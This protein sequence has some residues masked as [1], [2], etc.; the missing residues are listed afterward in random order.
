[1][2]LKKITLIVIIAIISS[3]SIRTFGTVFPQ[4]FNNIHMVKGTILVNTFFILSHL[5]FW[6]LF[7]RDYASLKGAVL[8]KTCLLP[9][10]GS[11]AVSLLYLKKLPFVFDMEIAFPLFL[12]NPYVDAFVPA[13]SSIF[14]LIFF[15]V[16][17]NSLESEE[18]RMLEKP[19]LS[20]IGGIS[21]FLVLHLIVLVNFIT[22]NT[23]EWLEHMPRTVAVGTVPLIVIAVFLMLHFYSRFYCFLDSVQS[24]NRR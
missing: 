7:Y 23:F 3:F 12:L 18:E 4:I 22:T 19:L 16:F 20:M 5:L 24:K 11:F 14:G 9:V 2:S 17:K 8:K 21:I 13:V 6:L 10:I 15:L 1:L